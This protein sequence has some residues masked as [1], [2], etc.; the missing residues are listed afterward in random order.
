M[1]LDRAR[2]GWI[3]LDGAGLG[4]NRA[5]WGPYPYITLYYPI[6]PHFDPTRPY[7]RVVKSG[8]FNAGCRGEADDL[9]RAA[10]G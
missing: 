1:G 2:W 3:G 6:Q 5:R 4:L 10:Y 9:P 7:P 8:L